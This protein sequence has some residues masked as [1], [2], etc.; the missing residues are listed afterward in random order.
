MIEHEYDH[1]GGI[2]YLDRLQ[3]L[4]RR[5]PAA[6]L[7]QVR[8]G[9]V[10]VPYAMRFSSGAGQAIPRSEMPSLPGQTA[11]AFDSSFAAK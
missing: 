11:V 9:E 10:K 1:T 3:P 2:L 5:M 4:G 6:K 7:E 8:K